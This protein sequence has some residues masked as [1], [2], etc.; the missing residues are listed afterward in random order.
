MLV[1]VLPGRLDTPTGGYVYDRR[2]VEGLRA[3]G[4]HVEVCSL[5]GNFP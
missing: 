1:L 3:L 5:D 2:I 4:W